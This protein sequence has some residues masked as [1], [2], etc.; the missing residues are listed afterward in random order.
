MEKIYENFQ[1]LKFFFYSKKEKDKIFGPKLKE[2]NIPL[3]M[4]NEIANF[5]M[6]IIVDVEKKVRILNYFS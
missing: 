2:G 6:N 4:F 5:H 1:K 3:Q